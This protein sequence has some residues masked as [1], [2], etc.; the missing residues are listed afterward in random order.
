M[1]ATELARLVAE[2]RTC[3]REYFRT[4][5]GSALESSGAAERRVDRAV[6]EVLRQPTLTF[7]DDPR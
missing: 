2:M 1:T 4:R 7:G 5:S 3:Q 6:E